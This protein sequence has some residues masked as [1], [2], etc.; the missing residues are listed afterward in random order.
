MQLAE[1]PHTGKADPQ[2]AVSRA[3]L[4]TLAVTRR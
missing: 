2:R 3:G 1:A 4:H